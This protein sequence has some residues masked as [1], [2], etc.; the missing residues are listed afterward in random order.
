MGLYC[1]PIVI[2]TAYH[3]SFAPPLVYRARWHLSPRIKKKEKPRKGIS[4]YIG[5]RADLYWSTHRPILVTTATNIGSHHPPTRHPILQQHRSTT[6]SY[7]KARYPSHTDKEYRQAPALLRELALG[8]IGMER[9]YSSLPVEVVDTDLTARTYAVGRTRRA[10]TRGDAHLTLTHR[11]RTRDHT[12]APPD[13]QLAGP[14]L[15]AVG[16]ATEDEVDG[17]ISDAIY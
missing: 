10:D 3:Y 2:H 12:V 8:G 13:H 1:K 16:M 4:T 9:S 7:N 11:A 15:P 5:R 17:A 14:D 6:S